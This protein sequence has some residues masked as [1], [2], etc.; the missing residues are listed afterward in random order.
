MSRT[1]EVQR[2]ESPVEANIYFNGK[3]GKFSLLGGDDSELQEIPL[4]FRF[5]VVDDGA[6]RVTGAKGLGKD[7]PKWKSTIAHVVYR[8]TVKVWL[9]TDSEKVYEGLWG[10]MSDILYPQ[11]ARYTK[12]LY[13]VTDFGNGKF[14]ACVH[15]K[16]RAFSRWLDFLKKNKIDP[17]GDVSFVVKSVQMMDGTKG[18]PSLVPVFE[19]GKLSAETKAVA[20]EMD[21]ELQAWLKTQFEHSD[22][23]AITQSR[24]AGAKDVDLDFPAHEIAPP[25][26][27]STPDFGE[28]L[29]F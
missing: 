27:G 20:D 22:I 25:F 7:A 2:T 26:K 19:V 6:H 11:G 15:L 18:E 12:L 9:E 28:D 4:P 10:N 29:P 13:V 21:T 3:L 5:T 16:G 23:P 8:N 14:L 1:R 24:T 17:C